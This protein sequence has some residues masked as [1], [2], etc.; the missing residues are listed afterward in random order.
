MAKKKD[1]HIVHYRDFESG[2]VRLGRPPKGHP[3]YDHD[4]LN[5]KVPMK[6][7]YIEFQKHGEKDA[8]GGQVESVGDHGLIAQCKNG[9]KHRILHHEVK[10]QVGGK[11]AEKYKTI[12]KAN[13]ITN[14]VAKQYLP[15]LNSTV[16]LIEGVAGYDHANDLNTYKYRLQNLRNRIISGKDI[17]NQDIVDMNM[18][19]GLIGRK[20]RSSSK[21]VFKFN[22]F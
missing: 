3:H 14:S 10:R 8:I 16:A 7:R 13:T 19:L 9:K 6:G 4:D 12:S 1:K 11:N 20:L 18:T 2:K 15:V 21:K 17:P 5:Y 22:K